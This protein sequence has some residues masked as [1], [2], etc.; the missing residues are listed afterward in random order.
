MS[1]HRIVLIEDSDAD[2]WLL[3]E[4]L[5]AVATNHE[6]IILKDGEEALEFIERERDGVEPR[7]CVIVLDLHLP[8]HD[9][10]ELL[11]AI[12]RAPAL[13]HVRALII[14]TMPSPQ[15]QRQI[16]EL[17]VAYAEK[18]NS[19]PGYAALATKVWELC[20]SSFGVAA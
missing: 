14:S 1:T 19:L 8:K 13:Q 12:R 10:L 11:A 7:P 15:I 5:K 18:P 3:Q 20:E 9:G 4:C 16:Q 6:L 17:G 2:V